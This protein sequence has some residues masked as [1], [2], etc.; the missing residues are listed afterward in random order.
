MATVR[1]IESSG[2]SSSDPE[3]QASRDGLDETTPLLRSNRRALSSRSERWRS[4]V[5]TFFDQNAGLLLVAASQFFFT[6]M[7]TCVKWLNSLDDEPVPMLEVRVPSSSFL[8][9]DSVINYSVQLIWIRMVCLRMCRC[10]GRH[11]CQ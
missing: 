6:A 1:T 10:A 8:A 7:T 4:A 5:S 3:I 2:Q 9:S 11:R